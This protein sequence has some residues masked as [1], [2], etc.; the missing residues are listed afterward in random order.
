MFDNLNKELEKFNSVQHVRIVLPL[1]EKGFF[2]RK[3]SNPECD[4]MFK[5]KY[6]D[7]RNI[8][9]D[10]VVYCPICK[11]EAPSTEWN[12]SEQFE[13]IKSMGFNHIQEQIGNAMQKDAQRFNKKQ[14]PGFISI[15]LSYKPGN[16][17]IFVPPSIAKELDQNYKCNI[18]N[19]R[20]SFL[21]S[22]YFCPACGNENIDGNIK[23]WLRN[24][25]NFI[26]KYSEM[27]NS[28]SN[29]LSEEDTNSYLFQLLEDHY[30]KIVSIFQS[31]AKQTFKRIL[32]YG[33][34][35]IRK[36]IFQNLDESSKKWKELT[37][38]SYEDIFD[39]TKYN[40]IKEHF[41]IRHLLIHTSGIIDEDFIKNTNNTKYEKGKRILI[42]FE[43]LKDFLSLT[44]DLIKCMNSNWSESIK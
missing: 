33:Q 25:N 28:F 3:C 23:K 16:T 17:I 1:D 20:Y 27:R 36:N 10:E 26:T 21:G 13:Y 37:D 40:R 6:E 9:N 34:I 11:H 12:T 18:C 35:K 29:F 2:D 44:N 32:G 8:V 38:K 42:S 7:W 31:F 43:S 22:A 24:I 39:I 30:C 4:R 15:S 14:K 41:Q 19:C 5:I